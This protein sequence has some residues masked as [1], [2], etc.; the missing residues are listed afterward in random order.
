MSAQDVIKHSH[1]SHLKIHDSNHTGEKL[2]ACSKCNKAFSQ[3]AHLKQHEFIH[4]GEKQPACS[5]CDKAFS[6]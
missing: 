4:S 6:L 2:Y 5:M 1:E 3:K